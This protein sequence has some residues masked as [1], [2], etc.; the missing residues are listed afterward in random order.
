MPPFMA[1][2]TLTDL[3]FSHPGGLFRLQVDRLE[4][5][6]GGAFGLLGPSGTG[7]T[8]LLRLMAGLLA[9]QRGGVCLGGQ[10][11][12]RLP[13]AARRAFRLSQVGLVFQDFALL[14]YLTVAEN[15]QLPQ[16]FTEAAADA[17]AGRDLAVRLE[18]DRHWHKP[19]GQLSQ[20]ERQRVAIA[21]AMAHG[22]RFLLADEPTASLDT[23][24][25][26]LVMDL[27]FETAHRTGACLV[28]VTHDPA[29]LPRFPQHA[30]V[31]DFVR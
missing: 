28:V 14:D 18:I 5:P 7:K 24:R 21:R 15:I 11:L 29:L 4:V 31:E 9:P 27:L 23:G 19:A 25:R 12:T 26:D 8:T 17:T 30:R 3:S 16:R 22:P 10:D 13:E 6:P 20:G 2:I 1:G